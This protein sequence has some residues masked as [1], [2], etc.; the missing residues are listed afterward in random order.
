MERV[1]LLVDDVRTERAATEHVLSGAGWNVYTAASS[2]D[3]LELIHAWLSTQRQV[4]Y[5]QLVIVFDLL[6]DVHGFYLAALVRE[7]QREGLLRM[8]PL[9]A[10][11]SSTSQENARM[12][13]IAG[14]DALFHKPLD[15]DEAARLEKLQASFHDEELGEEQ[16][17]IRAWLIGE[18]R[19]ML[20]LR[21]SEQMRGQQPWTAPEVEILLKLV[22]GRGWRPDKDA[23]SAVLRRVGSLAQVHTALAAQMPLLQDPLDTLL[24]QVLKGNSVAESGR[25]L[26][27]SR[28]HTYMLFRRLCEDLAQLLTDSL[29]VP[30]R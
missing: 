28:S 17:A 29:P 25:I 5:R 8:A 20:E 1:I 14:C 16:R 10:L 4:A 26:G 9:V 6:M 30:L 24:Q 12:A 3:G 13:S 18:G 11:T 2:I 15:E 22:S 27:Y 21:Q 23:T 19:Q 7:Q